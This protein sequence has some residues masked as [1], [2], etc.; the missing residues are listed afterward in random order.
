VSIA[1][2]YPGTELH[3][4]LV[5]NGFLTDRPLSDAEGH[6]LPHIEY[7]GL[8]H[9]SMMAAVNRFYD[10]YYFRPRVIWRI[11]RKALWDGDER[12]RLYQEAVEYLRLRTER[13]NYVR[14]GSPSKPVIAPGAVSQ[15]TASG[16][17]S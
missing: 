11:V 1:H 10:S 7:A 5:R 3:E 13:R 12:K 2:A 4:Y 6:Q 8:D 17:R 9:A 16:P 14:K 15:H